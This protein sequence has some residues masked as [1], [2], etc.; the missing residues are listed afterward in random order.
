M[1][2]FNPNETPN[3]ATDLAQAQI[4]I[5]RL[6]QEVSDQYEEGLAD[7]ER[8]GLTEGYDLGYDA[9]A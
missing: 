2:Y 8:A 1:E 4:E 6:W 7:G 3:F 5:A 9:V